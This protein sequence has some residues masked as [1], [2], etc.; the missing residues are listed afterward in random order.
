MPWLVCLP[1][2][3]NRGL[4]QTPVLLVCAIV[5][6]FTPSVATLLLLCRGERRSW[7]EIARTLGLGMGGTPVPS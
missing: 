6:M 5:M 4:M 3:L 2:W 7:R 1:L